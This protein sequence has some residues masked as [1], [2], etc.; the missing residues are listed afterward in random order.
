M[1]M[2]S[3]NIVKS[4]YFHSHFFFEVGMDYSPGGGGCAFPLSKYTEL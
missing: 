3:L 2:R 4:R 1:G